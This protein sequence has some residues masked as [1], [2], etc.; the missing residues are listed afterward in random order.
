MF[1][2]WPA[3]VPLYSSAPECYTRQT[4][5]W[6]TV[7]CDQIALSDR[8]FLHPD[9]VHTTTDQRAMNPGRRSRFPGAGL[10]S[11]KS[12]SLWQTQSSSAERLVALIR[13]RR[14][15]NQLADI[16]W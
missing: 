4:C 12:Q 3:A 11:G 6:S 10:P 9:A 14:L 2:F 5:L 8:F 1:A 15:A 13:A 7:C 16:F